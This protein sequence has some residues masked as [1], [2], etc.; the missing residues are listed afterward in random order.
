MSL[1]KQLKAVVPQR[2]NREC[3]TCKWV[4]DLSTEDQTAWIEW[5]NSDRSLTQLWEIAS[6]T[7]PNPLPISLAAMRACVREHWRKQ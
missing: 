2:S 1:A 5:V 4:R 3:S 7:E 6:R